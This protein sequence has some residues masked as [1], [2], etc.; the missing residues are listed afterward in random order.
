MRILVINCGSSSIKYQ[1]IE[2]D[3]E[4]V[5][6][7]GLLERVGMEG[8]LLLHCPGNGDKIEIPGN[9]PDHKI[10]IE[11]V[12]GALIDEKHGV[13]KKMEEI[14]AVGH[15]VVHGG[16][17]FSGSVIVTDE[18]M[19][20]LKDC[21]EL[22]PL[23][24]PANMIGIVACSSLLPNVPQVAVFD[25]A[26]HQTVP[27]KAYI[28]GIPYEYYKKH[29]IRRYGFHGTSHKYVSLRTAKLLGR[30][31]EELKIVT[32]HLGNG[33]SLTAVKGGKSIDTS[34][35]FGTIAGPVMGTRCGDID[36][37]I[38]PY[39]MDKEGLSWE[40][41]NE[42]LYKKSGLLG[43]SG[44]S[45]DMRDIEEAAASGNEQAQLAL[46]IFAY[47][48][49]KFI[50]AYAAAM[51]GVDAIVF[52]A[53]IGENGIEIREKICRGLEFL[54]AEIDSERNK[55]RGKEAEISREGSPV[56]ILVVP[57]NEE[58][59]IAQDTQGLVG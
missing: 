24:N 27:P 55:V 2:M 20:A 1:L 56:K 16:E 52:T 34:L 17:K 37:A 30:P 41:M 35:G 59:M 25:T 3:T 19:E 53:G 9:V 28:Y 39:L 11:M 38:V 58:L 6:A 46:D 48:N 57:T 49:R 44:I 43:I 32:C 47:N 36:P 4:R 50:G 23:H 21:S 40:D 5:L 42:V 33:C 14:D 15:R 51:G 29:G 8:S 12:L 7:R 45:S 26:F 13:I 54:G 22:A 10:G 31:I 18:V